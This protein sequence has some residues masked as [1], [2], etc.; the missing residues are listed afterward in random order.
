MNSFSHSRFKFFTILWFIV[1]G[2]SSSSVSAQVLLRN[3]ESG[4]TVEIPFGTKIFYQLYSDSILSVEIPKEQGVL[5]TTGDS[6]FVF[7]DQS[8]IVVNDVSYL[9]IESQKLKKWRAVMAP[10]LVAGSGVL[11][12]GLVMLSGE[13]TESHNKE[14]VPLHTG[15]GGVF[16]LGASLPFLMKNKSFDLKNS[17]W[18]LVIP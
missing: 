4:K 15:V 7:L 2:I 18:E 11:I 3:T 17:N 9:E 1:F 8:R 10:L 16:F 5:Q 14:I 6:T 13:G 12:R